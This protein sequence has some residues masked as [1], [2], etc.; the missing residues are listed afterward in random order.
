MNVSS[1]PFN[2]EFDDELEM[3]PPR[4]SSDSAPWLRWL[5]S[6]AAA[7]AAATWI[8]LGELVAGRGS[9]A[10]NSGKLRKAELPLMVRAA[11]SCARAA[12]SGVG[13]VPSQILDFFLG[14]L[15]S[16]THLPHW[17]MRTPL[18]VGWFP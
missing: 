17:R 13:K 16:D 1:S 15:I 18:Y 9:S 2:D 10:A 3:E 12:I 14:S 7:L 5:K 6:K 11:T 4:L 8:S